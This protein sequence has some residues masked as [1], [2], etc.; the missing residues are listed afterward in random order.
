MLK[1]RYVEK[2]CI[3]NQIFIRRTIER[4]KKRKLWFL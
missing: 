1:I 3:C 2:L 4:R